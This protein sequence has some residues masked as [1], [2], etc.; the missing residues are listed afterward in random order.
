MRPRRSLGRLVESLI[1]YTIGTH[2]VT[3]ADGNT[4]D[5]VK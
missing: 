5:A 1:I 2:G 4:S 3:G